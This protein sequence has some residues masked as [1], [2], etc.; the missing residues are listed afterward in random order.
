MIPALLR[1]LGTHL[2]RFVKWYWRRV[3]EVPL[4]FASFVSGGIF[5]GVAVR[6]PDAVMLAVRSM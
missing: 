6:A 4:V 2:L 5:V 3:K 1:K